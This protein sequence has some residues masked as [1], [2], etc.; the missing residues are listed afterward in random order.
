MSRAMFVA[1]AVLGG[2]SL[3]AFACGGKVSTDSSTTDTTRGGATGGG[4]S[5]RRPGGGTAGSGSTAPSGA[6]CRYVSGGGSG[7]GGNGTFQCIA[8]HQYSCSTGAREIECECSGT[9][10]GP[11]KGT[12]SCTQTF[13]NVGTGTTFPFD[14][15]NGCSPGPA[16]FATCGLPEPEDEPGGGFGS[17]SSTSSSGG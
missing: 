9:V 14:C 2:A 3:F 6:D 8:S 17:S 11:M 4:T 7:G 5:G 10:G 1:T 12:C 13:G 16:E 15:S